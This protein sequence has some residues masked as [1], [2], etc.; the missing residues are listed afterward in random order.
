MGLLDMANDPLISLGLGLLNAGGPSAKPVSL[1]QA[2]GAGVANMQEAQQNAMKQKMLQMQMKEAQQKIADAEALRNFDFGKYY[3]TPEQQA[4]GQMGPTPEAAAM[5][6]KLQ[7]KL[8]QQGLIAGLMG[9]KSPVLMQKGMDMMTKDEAPI[10]LADGGMLVTKTGRKLAEN[11]KAPSQ[12]EFTKLMMEVNSMPEGP[13][14]KLALSRLTTMSTH[15]PGA[16]VKVFNNTKDDFKNE[17][18]LRNDFSGSPI[19]KAHSEVDSAYRQIQSALKM[20]SP[21][22]DLAAATKIM[23]L[24]DPGS[25]VRESE[26]GMAMQANGLLDRVSNY[27]T[28]VMNGTK[29]TPAQR[30]DFGKLADELYNASVSQY[31]QKANESRS[32]A[33]DYKLNPDRIAKPIKSTI[34]GGGWSATVVK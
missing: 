15:A 33:S 23:K 2:L 31:N 30:V 3:Q 29:L 22:S 16:D 24:L 12:S 14:K 26:L 13:M 11:P 27:A 34:S 20:A 32:I 25:V 18:D 7:P 17:R 5:I 10:A 8:D 1:G 28:N 6:P 4:I 21:A 9:S 19:A